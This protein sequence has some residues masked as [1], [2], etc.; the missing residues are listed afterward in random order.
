MNSTL[1][2][3]LATVRKQQPQPV[4]CLLEDFHPSSLQEMKG[5]HARHQGHGRKVACLDNASEYSIHQAHRFNV[6]YGTLC[7]FDNLLCNGFVKL[8]LDLIV[9]LLF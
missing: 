2:G 3:W 4:G 7:I 8:A 1:D 6:E 9:N 5:S